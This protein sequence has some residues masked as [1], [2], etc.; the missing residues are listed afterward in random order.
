MNSAVSG[1]FDLQGRVSRFLSRG[2]GVPGP[3]SAEIVHGR[4]VGE[5]QDT[6]LPG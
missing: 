3:R 2:V 5:L 1:V 6:G 4:D